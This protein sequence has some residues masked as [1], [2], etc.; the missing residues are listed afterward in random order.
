MGKL[1]DPRLRGCTI[2]EVKVSPDLQQ[3]RIFFS[4]LGET[5]GQRAEAE[6][7]F[8]SAAAFVRR[9]LGDALKLRYTPEIVFE[10]DETAAHAARMNELLNQVRREREEHEATDLDLVQESESVSE[11]S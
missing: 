6:K 10:Y 7:G 11:K 8:K 2:L 3:A 1:S 5:V 9:S 4:I